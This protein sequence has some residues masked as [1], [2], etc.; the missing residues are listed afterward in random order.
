M[1][2]AHVN[3]G[4]A[5]H[6]L[7]NLHAALDCFDA[8]LCIDPSNIDAQWN[9]SQVLLTLGRYEEGFR[10]YETRWRH[11]K[12]NLKKRNFDSKLWL[13]QEPLSGK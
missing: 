2:V 3:K 9:K 6:L 11:P 4:L 10:L 13:G 5:E 8:A 7:M 1:V 12:I